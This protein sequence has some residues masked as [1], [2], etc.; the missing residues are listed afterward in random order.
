MSDSQIECPD[1]L[2]DEM[3]DEMSVFM[4]DRISNIMPDTMPDEISE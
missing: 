3:P 2:P 1:R 4:L